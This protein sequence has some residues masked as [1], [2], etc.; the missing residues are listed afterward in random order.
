MAYCLSLGLYSY[1]LYVNF[2]SYYNNPLVSLSY[3]AERCDTVPIVV[4]DTFLADANGNWEGSNNF[5]YADA[6]YSFTFSNF[7][8]KDKSEYKRMMAT[9]YAS[10]SE[11]SPIA[12]QQ[13]LAM[14]MALWNSYL[15]FYSLS[16]PWKT[17][18]TD[19]GKGTLQNFRFSATPSVTYSRASYGFVL[20]SSPT[21]SNSAVSVNCN[22]SYSMSY[23]K[24]SGV[25]RV[26]YPMSS[27]EANEA[28]WNSLPA[29]LTSSTLRNSF[30]LNM[31]LD[32]NS[33]STAVAVNMGF[34]GL[35]QL[36][37]VTA[38]ADVIEFEGSTHIGQQ[39]VDIR[40]PEMTPIYC[41]LKVDGMVDG[42]LTYALS[43]NISD[44]LCMITYQQGVYIPLTNHMGNSFEKVEACDCN[45][46]IGKSKTCNDFNLMLSLVAFP[47]TSSGSGVSAGLT[48]GNQVDKACLYRSLELFGRYNDSF[49]KLNN[50]S[51]EAAATGVLTSLNASTRIEGNDFSFC[52]LSDGTKCSLLTYFTLDEMRKTISPHQYMLQE[53]SC[54]AAMIIP[55][56]TW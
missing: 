54:S 48:S 35:D 12:K 44:P 6:S 19:I 39:F 36:I 37:P 22:T 40:Y 1:Y 34:E 15:R 25:Y 23:E 32:V 51:Y 52:Q 45:S 18:F 14:N 20:G 4:R 17:N 42:D 55:E 50:A 2:N 21:V 7:E 31:E 27:L 38:E 13:D 46:A 30:L 8:I 24:A 53:G 10:M 29:I 16:A 5:S 3:N 33:F 11:L 41:V 56:E 43:S 47:K 9:Y 28:C 49:K 26:S